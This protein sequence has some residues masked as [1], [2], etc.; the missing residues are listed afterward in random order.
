MTYLTIRGFRRGLVR[1]RSAVLLPLCVLFPLLGWAD[2]LSGGPFT[3]EYAPGDQALAEQSLKVLEAALDEF[4]AHFE[5][6]TAPILVRIAVTPE[7]F[8]RYAVRL[9]GKRV[10]GVAQPDKGVIAVKSPSLAGVEQDYGGTL[11]HELVHVLLYRTVGGD[12]LPRW[13]NEGL[14]MMLAGEYRW[15]APFTV[16]RMYAGRSIIPYQD[17]DFALMAPGTEM[18]F[19]SAYAQSLSMTRYLYGEMGS[20]A[21]WTLVRSCK[22]QYF[23]DA[24]RMYARQN[25]AEFFESYRASLWKVALVG[26]AASGFVVILNPLVF[27]W[28]LYLRRRKN[29]AIYKVWEDEEHEEGA[30]PFSW[31]EVVEDPDAWREGSGEEDPRHYPRG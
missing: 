8:Q 1:Y 26:L 7:E 25:P 29:Q 18:E 22:D 20:S 24:L 30:P 31:E 15:A 13:L 14:A 27:F 3:I 17:L 12:R 11:R 23:A 9:S 6:G 2:T 5:G 21:F 4:S 10:I 19:G 28:A 16:A